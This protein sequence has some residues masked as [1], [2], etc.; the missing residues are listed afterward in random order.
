MIAN[1]SIIVAFCGSRVPGSA[2][3]PQATQTFPGGQGGRLTWGWQAATA[4]VEARMRR[5]GSFPF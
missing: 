3:F 4:R 5:T 1:S 2:L